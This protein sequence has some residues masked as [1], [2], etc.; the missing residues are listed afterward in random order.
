[1]IQYGNSLIEPVKNDYFVFGTIQLMTF[2]KY[3]LNI[4]G[5]HRV[6]EF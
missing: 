1:M 6:I 3:Q 4:L 5:V 2:H